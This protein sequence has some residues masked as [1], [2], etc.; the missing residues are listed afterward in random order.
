LHSRLGQSEYISTSETWYFD[1][2]RIPEI[3]PYIWL[4]FTTGCI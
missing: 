1:I 4:S 2:Y 3:V